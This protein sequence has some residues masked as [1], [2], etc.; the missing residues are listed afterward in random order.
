M[1]VITLV[2]I[3]VLTVDVT[4]CILCFGVVVRDVENV[5]GGCDTGDKFVVGVTILLDV[6]SGLLFVKGVVIGDIVEVA[7]DVPGVLIVT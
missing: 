4:V 2:V 3:M 7:L 1:G 5:V 6:K